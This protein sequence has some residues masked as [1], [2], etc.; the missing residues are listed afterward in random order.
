MTFLRFPPPASQ[1]VATRLADASCGFC[2]EAE[3]TDEFWTG[4]IIAVQHKRRAICEACLEFSDEMAA[5]AR[6]ARKPAKAKPGPRRALSRTG[7]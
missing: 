6:L 2:L 4:R 7:A 5:C 3:R 1:R